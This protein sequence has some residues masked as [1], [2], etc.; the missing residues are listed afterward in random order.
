MTG[1]CRV[2]YQLDGDGGLSDGGAG[3]YHDQ[4]AALEAAVYDVVQVADTRW[5]AGE[6]P[7]VVLALA[8]LDGFRDL[9]EHLADGVLFLHGLVLDGL[10]G[11][12][13]LGV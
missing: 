2:A 4:V 6:F 5:D 10:D 7:R 3:G 9:V 8:L 13:G 11:V 1:L 12:R